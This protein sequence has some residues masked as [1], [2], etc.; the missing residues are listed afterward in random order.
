VKTL[1]N[2]YKKGG[3]WF[4]VAGSGGGSGATVTIVVVVVV[5]G[6]DTSL[7]LR[8]SHAFISLFII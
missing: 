5:L 7:D 1:V 3:A 8:V 6:L 4:C 2:N